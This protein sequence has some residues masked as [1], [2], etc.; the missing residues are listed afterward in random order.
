[1][2]QDLEFRMVVAAGKWSA[3]KRFTE[4]QLRDSDGKFASGSDK[5]KSTKE[6]I[7]LPG[8]QAM[9]GKGPDMPGYG[10]YLKYVE[11][12]EPHGTKTYEEW[13][14]WSKK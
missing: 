4:D 8:F 9:P 13:V 3:A 14:A 7:Q 11:F 12:G 6:K 5:E 1:M 2:D 10:D